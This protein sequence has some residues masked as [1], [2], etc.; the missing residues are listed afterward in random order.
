MSIWA[1]AAGSRKY[2]HL[3]LAEHRHVAHEPAGTRAEI[4]GLVVGA[5][6]V[7]EKPEIV[8]FEHAAIAE[9]RQN[10]LWQLH[11]DQSTAPQAKSGI[12][13][14]AALED[15]GPGD[16]AAA[17][18][19]A[20]DH[21]AAPHA[22]AKERSGIAADREDAAP[23]AE[24]LAYIDAAGPLAG[25]A[26]DGDAAT[27]HAG[28]GQNAGISADIDLAL[29]H[30]GA[31]ISA[32]IA[33]DDDRTL[34]HA[35]ADLVA[36][37]VSAGK[38]DITRVTARDLEGVTDGEPHARRSDRE[39]FDLRGLEP[40]EPF[41]QQRGKVEPLIRRASQLEGQSAHA[42]ISFRWKWCGPRLPP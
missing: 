41:R 29:L 8:E 1:F 17:G 21:K 14:G 32:G 27:R 19:A 20:D 13:A 34:G 42:R 9:G 38:S 30:A 11:E 6:P 35:G 7:F 24:G 39:R 18:I 3:A 2:E 28:A 33:I 31:E 10:V 15:D 16:H 12:G 26:R 5:E 22:F 23:H 40:V 25:V 4:D 37:R 36:A